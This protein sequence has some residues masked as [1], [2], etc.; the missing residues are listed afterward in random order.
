[1]TWDYLPPKTSLAEWRMMTDAEKRERQ[2]KTLRNMA[3]DAAAWK[4]AHPTVHGS[5]FVL[6]GQHD[7]EV[8]LM[9]LLTG[10]EQLEKRG[11]K[12]VEGELTYESER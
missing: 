7:T 10:L 2:A 8:A 11:Y 1:M 4:A 12:T 6:H 3:D 9:L 5:K